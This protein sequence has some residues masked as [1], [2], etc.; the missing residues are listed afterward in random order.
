M[1]QNELLKIIKEAKEDKRT[2][3]DLSGENITELPEVIGELTNLEWLNLSYNQLSTLPEVIGQLTNLK[4][5]DLYNNQ[6]SILPEK[7]GQLTNLEKLHLNNNQLS[8]FPEV[9]GQLTNLKELNLYNNQLSTFPEEIGQLTNLKELN[10]YNNQ[11]STF[12]EVIGQLTNLETL[13]LNDNQLSTLP[14]V[15]GQLNSLKTLWLHN[16]QLSTFPE[17]IGQL[18]KLQWLDLDDNPTLNIPPEILKLKKQ[19]SKIIKYYLDTLAAATKSLNEAKMLLVG[20]G[21]VG[22]TSLIKR[23]VENKFNEGETKTEGIDIRKWN[24]L[25]DDGRK[26]RLNIWD[27][28]GQEIMHSTHQFFL[29]KRS[30][31]ILVWDAR[32]ED[33]YGDVEYWLELIESFGEDAPVIVVVNKIDIN[34]AELDETGLA[35]KY[36]N[37]K[38][39]LKISCKDDVGIVKLHNTIEKEI[40][41]LKHIETKWPLKWFNIKEKLENSDKDYIE[42]KEYEKMCEKEKIDKDS[43]DTLINFLHDLGIILY[44]EDDMRLCTTNILNPEWVTEGVYK[45]I[46]SK[47]LSKHNGVLDTK[48]LNNILDIKEY[49]K[50]KQMFIIDMMKKFEICFELEGSKGERFLIPDVF[51]K[52]EPV[53][54]FAY[55]NSIK[56]QYHYNFLPPSII[57]RFIVRMHPFLSSDIYWRNGVVLTDGENRALVKADIYARKIY[58][59]IS[60]E[61]NLRR[62][63]L[64][65]IRG[66]FEHIHKTIPK[67]NAKEMIPLPANPELVMSYKALL[68]LEKKG[69]IEYYHPDYDIEIDV[70]KLLDG[71]DDK[72][73]RHRE[74]LYDTVSKQIRYLEEALA[75]AIDPLLKVKYE[76]E[77]EEAKKKL[78]DISRIT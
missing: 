44:Y 52:K 9:I 42:H 36:K 23:L 28:G 57:S 60:G 43:K 19:P 69:V 7:I 25:L 63:F 46:N 17:E 5:L 33:K 2:Y 62:E 78:Y 73:R 6:L 13:W 24:I 12:P 49:P 18:T 67:I 37:I 38:S 1:N 27:F 40:I 71:I 76:K 10:L 47:E 30:L 22:K 16:N 51:P 21:G 14:E 59:Y 55:K 66:N 70:K 77:L 68:N 48:E 31:Y 11:L 50:D 75:T 35:K 45:I 32:Q 41:K 8:T 65:K 61:D 34:N 20:Q 72:T 56:F 58:I 26:I 74:S 3:L 53:F 54:E 64:T 15:I 29:T 39:F 4:E